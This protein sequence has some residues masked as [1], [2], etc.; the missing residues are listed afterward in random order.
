MGILDPAFAVLDDE[1]DSG[2]DIDCAARGRR[3]YQRD[4]AGRGQ[5]RAADH[6]LPAPARRGVKPDKVS[7]LADGRIVRT[8]GPEIALRLEQEGYDAVMADA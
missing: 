4:H 6:P 5:G 8:G 3:R 7:I 1:T 2:L